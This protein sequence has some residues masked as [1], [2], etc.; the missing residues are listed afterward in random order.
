MQL[1]LPPRPVSQRTI[2][3]I[4]E[5]NSEFSTIFCTSQGL[6]LL[7]SVEHHRAALQQSAIIYCEERL[8]TT[9]AFPWKYRWRCW[10]GS[11][12]LSSGI[13]A[14]VSQK[15]TLSLSLSLSIKLRH[16][17]AN[18][19]TH[20]EKTYQPQATADCVCSYMRKNS[21]INGSILTEYLD[22]D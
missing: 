15:K 7:F 3:R 4:F 5:R 2:L 21:H 22:A 6:I 20:A 12:R 14:A 9:N 11:C 16:A 17:F 18:D 1:T 19:E 10:T 13:T 8:K